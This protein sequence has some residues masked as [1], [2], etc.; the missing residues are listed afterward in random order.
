MSFKG[1]LAQ[2]IR[3]YELNQEYSLQVLHILYIYRE[4]VVSAITV[5]DI[6]VLSL[7]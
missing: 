6:H 2:E 7:V 3:D 5:V 1:V 4:R